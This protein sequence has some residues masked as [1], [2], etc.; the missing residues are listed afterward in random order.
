M[1]KSSCCN[2]FSIQRGTATSA[3]NLM[4]RIDRA[5]RQKFHAAS[6]VS[7]AWPSLGRASQPGRSQSFWFSAVRCTRRDE[8][9]F[10]R[11]WPPP[12]CQ[13]IQKIRTCTEKI[14]RATFSCWRNQHW[15]LK[16]KAAQKKTKTVQT[17]TP[18]NCV[19]EGRK[20][21]SENLTRLDRRSNS[22]IVDVL[23]P[24]AVRLKSLA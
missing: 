24:R 10:C 22:A 4:F 14:P 13:G 1:T 17:I 18:L 20:S 2:L 16:A 8:Y 12:H 7:P 19:R 11:Q 5:P 23:K 3:V 6:E 21:P 9:A 15:S